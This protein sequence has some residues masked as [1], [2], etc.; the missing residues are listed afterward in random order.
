MKEALALLLLTL[1]TLIPLPTLAEDDAEASLRVGWFPADRYGQYAEFIPD[2]YAA[3][4]LTVLLNEVEFHDITD[5]T[6]TWPD[7]DAFSLGITLEYDGYYHD[8]RADGWIRTSE[9]DGLG[10]KYAQDARIMEYV[11]N[12]LSE[13]GYA[14]F[15]PEGLTVIVRAELCDGPRYTGEAREP[16]VIED[17]DQLAV[18]EGLLRSA[19]PSDA[20][21]C[22]FGYAQL[23]LT[24]GKGNEFTLYP[25]TDSCAQYYIGG[26]F[27]NYDTRRGDEDHN[28]NQAMFD[29]FGINPTDYF[30]FA[31]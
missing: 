18:L 21:G 3:R 26:S 1:L 16:L 31:E 4:E 10:L 12:L 24:N 15:D 20:S 5:F 11:M 27:F 19:T 17:A 6:G 8:L 7:K 14:P 13:K 28:T 29:L 23:T 9:I 22:P 2:E 25:A 30:H